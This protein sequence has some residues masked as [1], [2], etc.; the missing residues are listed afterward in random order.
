MPLGYY[1]YVL[2]KFLRFRLGSQGKRQ[3]CCEQNTTETRQT[4]YKRGKGGVKELV[5]LCVATTT[6]SVTVTTDK[7]C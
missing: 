2:H 3:P 1:P 6:V 7:L 4:F 5:W